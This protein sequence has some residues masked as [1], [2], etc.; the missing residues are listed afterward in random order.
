MK[1]LYY[2]GCSLKGTNRAY[3]ESVLASFHAL[4]IE[5]EE[6]ED[7]NCC[8]ATAYMAVDEMKS[9][10]LAARNLALAERQGQDGSPTL[11]APCSGCYLVLSK[12]Q[13]YM[14]EYSE[15]SRTIDGALQAARLSYART[16]HVRHP[17][18]ILVN[19]IGIPQISSKVQRPLRG[20]K[21]ACYYGCQIVRP[22]AAFD[23]QVNPKTMDHLM[24]ALGA[25]TVDWPLKTRC[26]GG[27]LM[28][29]L[30]DVGVPL[31]YILLKEA[32]KRGA[33]V[34]ATACPLCQ[35]NLECYQ[36]KMSRQ[37]QERV[38]IPVVYF[39]QLLGLALGVPERQLGMHRLLVP[40]TLARGGARLHA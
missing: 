4:N 25:E 1:Y 18:D 8:G 11:I 7:W 38:E 23:D 19:E 3:E 21:V 30:P 37:F 36:D 10:A 6:L 17:L 5:L 24:R 33:H 40:F 16:V 35:F 9:F 20:L 2:P 34:V 13:H 15:V 27:S 39:T 26:C 32:L 31:S 22:Y 29:T 12:T 14:E 28:G